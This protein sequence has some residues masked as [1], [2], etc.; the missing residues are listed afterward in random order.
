MTDS[1]SIE[2]LN[3]R[4]VIAL[5][6]QAESNAVPM[7]GRALYEE[8]QLIFRNSQKQVPFRFGIAKG[9]G[10]LL[11]PQ[12][13]GTQVE[14]T[15]GYGGA[16]SKY[17]EI[18]HNTKTMSFRNGKKSHFVEDPVEQAQMGMDARLLKR[19]SKIAAEK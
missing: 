13:A 19:V 18:I 7:L 15:V 16:A 2:L 12:V 9:S 4:Q 14:V 8:G 3:H 5:L 11:E 10:R 17:I 1:W 6:A